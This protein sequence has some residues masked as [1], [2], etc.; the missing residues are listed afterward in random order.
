MQPQVSNARISALLHMSLG[1]PLNHR[2]S[3]LKIGTKVDKNQALAM[4]R[5]QKII[6][7]F[8]I[9]KNKTKQNCVL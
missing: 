8:Q 6:I 7:A 9:Q 3:N 1:S 4:K 5:F 2:Q